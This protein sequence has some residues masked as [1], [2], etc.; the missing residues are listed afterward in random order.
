MQF[1]NKFFLYMNFHTKGLLT[2]L[3]SLFLFSACENPSGVGLEID[4]DEQL[5]GKKIDTLSIRTVTLKDD[6]S[7][8]HSMNHARYNGEAFAQ[9]V[10]GTLFDP[11]IGN[12]TASVAVDLLKPAAVPRI[13]PEATIDSVVLVL[14][15]G[16]DYFGDTLNQSSFTIEVRQ[17]AENFVYN[18][19]TSKTWMT[20]PEVIGSRTINRFAYRDSVSVMQRV[21]DR[22]TLVRRIPQLRIPLSA[23]FF[24]AL[25][26]DG[27]DSAS[28]ST[29]AGFRDRVKGLHVSVNQE[30][31]PTG[32]GGLVTFASVG[33]IS[34]VELTY[35]QPN[36]KDGDDADIDTV[37][38]L[39]PIPAQSSSTGRSMGMVSSVTHTYTDAVLEQLADED[40]DFE[41]L[42]LQAPAGLRA[43]VSFPFID[44]L[45][46]RSIVVNKAE[47]VIYADADETV[48]GYQAPRIGLY[49]EDIAGQR[50][51]VPDGDM[52]QNGDPRSQ[53]PNFGGFYEQAT[54]RYVFVLTSF[55][56]DVLEGKINNAEVFISPV[57]PFDRTNPF[58]SVANTGS[59]AVVGG[60]S[61]PNYRMKLNLYYTE[62]N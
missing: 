60:G 4:P 39:L 50:Q 56:Q 8:Y 20:F 32:P 54:K 3:I 53:G 52:R 61:H 43:K 19:H 37:R 10:F 45:K 14:P 42:Y 29:E 26:N 21:N 33:D 41:T 22:D 25:L 7:R 59:R 38:T 31:E 35:R 27:V 24:K 15:Y 36:G 6:S 40:G 51:P 23:D 1:L 46:G 49:R 44:D 9:T 28:M 17:L 18:A 58:Q 30:G 16:L 57:S 13:K 55:I 11:I 5:T 47:L 34:G 48:F 62:V 12:T 2:L